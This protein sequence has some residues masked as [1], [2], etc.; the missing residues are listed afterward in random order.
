MAALLAVAML[1]GSLGLPAVAEELPPAE[2]PG[3]TD[4]V[5]AGETAPPS[6]YYGPSYTFLGTRADAVNV[7]HE[8]QTIENYQR[9]SYRYT[10]DGT[11]PTLGSAVLSPAREFRQGMHNFYARITLQN[12]ATVKVIAIADGIP[13]APAE[14]AVNPDRV[15]SSAAYGVFPAN[16]F[17]ASTTLTCAFPGQNRAQIYYA[18]GEAS[19]DYANGRLAGNTGI[20]V[21]EQSARYTAGTAISLT[22][23]ASVNRAFVIEALAV[24][25]GQAGEKYSSRSTLYFVSDPNF[26]TLTAANVD[27][28]VKQMSLEEKV[29]MIMPGGSQGLPNTGVAGG[30]AANARLGIPKTALSDGPA[31]VRMGRN[32]TV[33]ISPAGI[34][35]TWD[36]KAMEAVAERTGVEAKHYAVD[37]MLAPGMNIY[38]NPAGGRNFEYYSEDPVITGT[39]A[40]AYTRMLLGSNIGVS[41][42]HYA[43][44]GQENTRRGGEEIISERALREIYLRGFEMAVEEDP[45]TVMASYNQINSAISTSNKWLMT[46][47]LRGDWGFDGYVVSDW[48][49]TV[50]PVEAVKAQMDMTQA[51]GMPKRVLDWV[52]SAPDAAEKEARTQLV[53]RSAKNILNTVVKTNSFKG[54]YA[55][56]TAGEITSRSTGFS[57]SEVYL[58]SREV[59]RRVAA[60]GMV[61]LKNDGRTLPLGVGP[62]DDATVALITSSKA[63]GG[64]ASGG[65][66]IQG[67]GSAAVTF[68]ASYVTPLAGALG[69]GGFNV[70]YS[71][72]DNAAN[73]TA[74]AASAAQAAGTFIFVMS[75]P[76]QEG[77]DATAADFD[78]S[79]QEQAV[80]SAFADAFH[81]EGKKVVA[82]LNCGSAVNTQLFNEKADAI[83]HVWLAGS[84]GA[85]AITDILNGTANPSGKLTQTFP[86]TLVDSSSIAMSKHSGLSWHRD[87][88]SPIQSSILSWGTNPSYF[89]EGVYV[90][91]R[92]FDTFG[93][94]DRV[95]YPFGHGLSY[96]TFEF[97][98]LALS[99]KT[100]SPTDENDT[101]TA[102]VRVTNT[103]ESAGRAVAELYLSASSYEEEGRPAKELKHY[104]K[105]AIL[106]PGKYEDV[107][108][109]IS[110]RDL[111]Y[112]DDGNSANV[113]EIANGKSTVQ[114][115]AGAGWT[116]APDTRFTV[117]VGGTSDSAVLAEQG[118]SGA[119][120]YGAE[121]DA[122]L[123]ALAEE[124]AGA[125]AAAGELTEA[126]YTPA[127][128]TGLAQ[129]AG[130]A[131]QLLGGASYTKE[132]LEAAIA[133]IAAARLALAAVADKAALAAQLVAADAIEN[134]GIYTEESALAF[135]A[136]TAEARAVMND[137][138]AT[139][140]EADAAAAKL[141]LAISG[142]ELKT[143]PGD[144]AALESML[145]S[146]VAVETVVFTDESAGELE[147]AIGA[148]QAVAGDA[149]AAQAQIDGALAGLSGAIG[150][151]ALK[152]EFVRYAELTDLLI[153]IA[154]TDGTLYTK[155]SWDALQ[156]IVVEAWEFLA[157]EADAQAQ[158]QGGD[159]YAPA[160]EPIDGEEGGEDGGLQP[161]LSVADARVQ[162]LIVKLTEAK[163][164]LRLAPAAVPGGQR[165]ITG[166][167]HALADKKTMYAE[168][169]NE[170]ELAFAQ[171]EFKGIGLQQIGT[172]A[173]SLTYKAADVSA[174]EFALPPGDPQVYDEWMDLV[175]MTVA[176]VTPKIDGYKTFSIVIYAKEGVKHFS[177]AN[178]APLLNVKL[179]AA[180]NEY[181]TMS[182]L[183]SWLDA[184]Y[185]DDGYEGGNEG[186]QAKETLSPTMASTLLDIWS[187]FDVNRDGKV[188]I[189][190]LNAV[191]Q[192]LGQTKDPVTGWA[193]PLIERCDLKP[194]GEIDID[195]LTLVMAKYNAGL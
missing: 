53:E 13:S 182:L 49:A 34:A 54:V 158:P 156:A 47:V 111:Q 166:G 148:A 74:G 56:L 155:A 72:A 176:E 181:R 101:I 165:E 79:A 19:Y 167:V 127:S 102:T 98:N 71:S 113:L 26:E 149:G 77:T 31:G 32:A 51:S 64:Q 121:I 15:A 134:I 130:A 151:L 116:V 115:S 22:A 27:K 18:T 104:A 157:D 146:A 89:D 57:S 179:T 172:L 10:I 63:S 70:V 80:F 152:A 173:L 141:G 14:L 20:T 65:L 190:D 90:G 66:L 87:D 24:Y 4:P 23:P 11:E 114:Y 163:N 73:V 136:A 29:A 192:Y 159:P 107:A 38:R 128:W 162:E 193:S 144:S 109:T 125:I 194:D 40:A 140:G 131:Q 9:L 76:G 81:A 7:T 185:Y 82:L 110:K 178:G 3:Y 17:P 43:A 60:E 122:E 138:N 50:D 85:N 61:L 59:N 97:S 169:I 119:F 88:P 142:L 94:E 150:G 5:E 99:K 1:L 183:L 105:T 52:Y 139:Q 58:A 129:A 25:T 187:R 96:T 91:Y 75:R 160:S 55:D 189:L 126:D 186:L 86:K 191:R 123:V 46:D 103:G 67:G 35:S 68:N 69:N 180:T 41:L 45:W 118:V 39:V 21:S 16:N 108:F 137:A 147:L 33:W 30:S 154:Q 62:N 37:V 112:F 145:D 106:E 153:E 177:V 2:E 8:L 133:E 188:S 36:E 195:D 132:Q 135:V 93:M 120:T 161:L 117:T 12:P 83:L 48:G 95:A 184:A 42:K 168:E 28:V 175:N 170:G 124:L 92:Y 171:F 164:S 6:L 100:F 44:N 174:H 84:E 78:M 143:E